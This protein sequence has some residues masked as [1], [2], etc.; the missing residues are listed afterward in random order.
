MNW[1][2]KLQSAT[3]REEVINIINQFSDAHNNKPNY[4]FAHITIDDYNLSDL[5][6]KYCLRQ[7]AINDWFED[8]I[9]QYGEKLGAKEGF[10]PTSHNS[11]ERCNYDDLTELRD[12]IIGFLRALLKVDEEVRD[13]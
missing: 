11:W 7:D 13:G 1:N 2:D 10:D 4:T 3:T 12:A 9:T 5:H 6:I 8:Q